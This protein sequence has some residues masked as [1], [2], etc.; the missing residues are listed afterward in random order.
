LCRRRDCASRAEPRHGIGVRADITLRAVR[1]RVA[2]RL[3]SITAESSARD[4]TTQANC[5][6][7]AV[8]LTPSEVV[9]GWRERGSQGCWRVFVRAFSVV[10][11]S[12]IALLQIGLSLRANDERSRA[13]WLH[14]W[15]RVACQVLGIS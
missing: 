1:I 11:F 10:F 3:T 7:M 15:C 2:K 4:M 6:D 9:R 13:T 8:S 14:R 5:K 12:I